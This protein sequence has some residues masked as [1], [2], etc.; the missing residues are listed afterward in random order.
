M[1]VYFSLKRLAITELR[2]KE[3]AFEIWDKLA[4]SELEIMG[5]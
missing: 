4:V 3:I 5:N 2:P 1:H